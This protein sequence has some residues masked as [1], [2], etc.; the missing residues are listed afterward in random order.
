MA[1]GRAPQGDHPV[2]RRT[3]QMESQSTARRGSNQVLKFAKIP[4]NYKYVSCIGGASIEAHDLGFG[5]N[6]VFLHW[7]HDYRDIGLTPGEATSL[8]FDLLKFAQKVDE[9]FAAS[10]N[11]VVIDSR[12]EVQIYRDALAKLAQVDDTAK[13]SR[14]GYA[15]DAL[16]AGKKAA[17]R[18]NTPY[19][20]QVANVTVPVPSPDAAARAR[21]DEIV[22]GVGYVS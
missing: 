10:P 6:A 1:P 21:A 17:E 11:A 19:V 15:N 5:D 2:Q 3:V 20:G 14:C 8:A 18:A 22:F 12:T 7:S 4:H 9:R 13:F 16:A